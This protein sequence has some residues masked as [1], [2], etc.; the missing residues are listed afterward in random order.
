[1]SLIQFN[2]REHANL[3]QDKW[4]VLAILVLGKKFIRKLSWFNQPWPKY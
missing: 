4:P 3:L 1:L 2:E